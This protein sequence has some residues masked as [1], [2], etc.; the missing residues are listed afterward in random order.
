M[1]LDMH[2][3][4]DLY[5]DPSDIIQK[6]T[7]KGLYVLSITTTPNAYIGTHRLSA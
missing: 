2:C 6:C 5:K 4:L 3:H 7:E 1:K